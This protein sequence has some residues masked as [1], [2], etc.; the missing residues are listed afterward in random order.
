MAKSIIP[1]FGGK[2]RLAPK[3]AKLIPEDH[4]IYCEAFGGAASVLMAKKPSTVEVYND[5]NEG[6]FSLFSVLKDPAH[7]AKF[8]AQL[9]L[10]SYSR[11]EFDKAEE[12]WKCSTDIVERALAF[13]ILARQSFAATGKTWGYDRAGSKPRS[14]LNSLNELPKIHERIDGVT[15]DNNDWRKVI[16]AYDKPE[17]VFYLD[18]PYVPET[19]KSGSYHHEITID[20]HKDLVNRLLKMQGRALLSGYGHEVYKPLEDHGWL[21]ISWEHSCTAAGHTRNTKMSVEEQ[22]QANKRIE[23]LWVHPGIEVTSGMLNSVGG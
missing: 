10:T 23:C 17:T 18:P 2:H 9:Q 4:T 14:F 21:K 19:R 7:F 22:S 15:V 6:L 1:W 20:D 11:R 12:R 5:V 8:Y 13:Y 16:K 3:I